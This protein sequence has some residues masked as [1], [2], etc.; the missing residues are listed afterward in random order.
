VAGLC[1]NLQL[2]PCENTCPLNMNIP[3]FLQ[4]LKEDRIDDAFEQ[5]V[6]DNPLP[7]TTGRVCQH[8]CELRCRRAGA[9]AAVNMRETHRYI[10]DVMYEGD[11]AKRVLQRILKRKQS[12]TGKKIAVVGAGPAGLSAAFYLALLGHKVTVY[13]RAPSAGGLLR[14][15]LPEYRL[16]KKIMDQE[17]AFIRSAGFQFKFKAELGKTLQLDKLAKDNDAVFLALG[18]W[19]EQALGVPG[20][21]AKG[22]LSSL[23]FLN[24]AA[25]G[26]KPA[27][28]PKVAVIG[29]GNSAIDAARTAKR[30]GAD[31]TIVYR[32]SRG[33]M[34]AIPDET[35]QALEEGVKLITMAAPLRVITGQTGKVT[36]LEVAKTIPGKYDARG[37]RTPVVTKDTYVVPCDTI[38]KAIGERPEGKLT[39]TLGLDTTSW[40]SLKVDPWTLQTSNPKIYA[41]GDYVTG[42]TNVSTTMGAGKKAAKM[43]D[44]QLTGLDRFEELW[45]KF[46]YDHTIPPPSQGGPRN[47]AR[48]IA[49]AQRRGNV[50]VSPT[51]TEWQAKAECFRCLRCDIKTSGNGEKSH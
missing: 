12:P 16:P 23:S 33:E 21:D 40:G 49:P 43:I 13:D 18:T 28:G 32:R 47:P 46:D 48:L 2:S 24:D 1:G 14:Y 36:G 8:P 11:G 51:F 10:G 31:V 17:L 6:M 30:L 3:G 26:K 39:K 27:I 37:R 44:R 9:D 29:G 41:G 42:A 35:E 15:A 25:V 50:E 19:E 45:P 38:I 20:D 22:L 4:L 34:P 7:S 5:V